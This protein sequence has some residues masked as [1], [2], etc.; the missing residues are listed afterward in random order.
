MHRCNIL[1]QNASQ[2][3]EEHQNLRFFEH[4][5]FFGETE[6]SIELMSG[7]FPKYHIKVNIIGGPTLRFV[8]I[9]PE[10]DARVRITSSNNLGTTYENCSRLERNHVVALKSRDVGWPQ[11]SPTSKYKI[12]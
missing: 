12:I 6:K 3:D 10:S 7:Q 1:K 9:L 4:V 2:Y 8:C 11:D 5:G